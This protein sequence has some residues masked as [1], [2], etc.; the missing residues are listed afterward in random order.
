MIRF[1]LVLI[2]VMLALGAILL[3]GD[4]K[5]RRYERSACQYRMIY[6]Y[7]PEPAMGLVTLGGSR[8]RVSTSATHFNELLSKLRPEALPVH[9]LAHSVYAI[10]KEYVILRDLLENHKPKSVLVMIK[11]RSANFGSAHPSFIEIARLSDIPLA[12]K[13][14]WPESRMNALLAARDILLQHLNPLERVG[15]QH[16][17]MTDRNCDKLDYRLNVQ[18][19]HSAQRI[20]EVASQKVLDW[21]LTAPSERG[22]LQWMAAFQKLREKTGV[23]FIFLLMTGTSEPLPAADMGKKF[24]EITGMPL[25]TLDRELHAKLSAGGK[26]D[27]SHLNEIGR[28]DFIPWLI[29]KIE[30]KCRRSDGC[31]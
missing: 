4:E 21:D 2:C 18:S 27:S 7:E 24:E 30:Q 5:E 16:S 13:T 15:K 23:E 22:F 9:N 12:I 3:W 17:E 19:L 20:Y 26:R 28:V 11:P 29:G 6:D 31:L 1:R 25:I 10:G 14:I 8:V